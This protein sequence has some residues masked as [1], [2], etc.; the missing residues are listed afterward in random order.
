LVIS[1]KALLEDLHHLY[2]I[3][4]ELDYEAAA[5]CVSFANKLTTKAMK[6]P[7]GFIDEIGYLSKVIH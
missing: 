5:E 7:D 6:I 1:S 3:K 4:S 2:I